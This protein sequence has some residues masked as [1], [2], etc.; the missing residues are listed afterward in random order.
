MLIEMPKFLTIQSDEFKR[1]V[2][3]V[4]KQDKE[5]VVLVKRSKYDNTGRAKSCYSKTMKTE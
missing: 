2:N 1:L 4:R 5:L 3:H